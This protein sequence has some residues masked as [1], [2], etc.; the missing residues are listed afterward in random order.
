MLQGEENWI[1]SD[2]PKGDIITQG[3]RG[4]KGKG[5]L[6]ASLGG[7]RVDSRQADPSPKG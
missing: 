1:H 6:T 4:S 5:M 7:P 2:Y 3:S